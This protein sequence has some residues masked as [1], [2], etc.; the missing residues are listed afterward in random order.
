M[1]NW[2]IA[3]LIFGISLISIAVT[4]KVIKMNKQHQEEVRTVE[5]Q[6]Q[7]ELLKNSKISFYS[8]SVKRVLTLLNK[9]RYVSESQSFRD[10]VLRLLAFKTGDIV[11]KKLDSS[12]VLITDVIIGG[13][14]F[15]YYFRYKVLNKEGKEEELKPEFLY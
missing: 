6:Y 2:Q 4:S 14:R 10:S 13:G 3:L 9:Y 5:S 15:D 7:S 12:K 1:K 11:F 8:D